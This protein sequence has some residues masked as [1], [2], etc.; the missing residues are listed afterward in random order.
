MGGDPMRRAGVLGMVVAVG[1]GAGHLLSQVFEVAVDAKELSGLEET[2]TAPA[3]LDAAAP[4]APLPVRLV[5]AGGV[6]IPADTA[7][8]GTSYSHATHAFDP[9]FLDAAPWIDPDGAARV[10]AD[11]R[12]YLERMARYGNNAVTVDVFLELILFEAIGDGFAVYGPDDPYR[13]RH[14]AF[15][16]F[17]GGLV[18]DARARGMDVYLKQQTS[19]PEP[20]SARF[21]DL[22]IPEDLELLIIRCMS[23]K[24]AERP[25]SAEELRNA[26]LNCAA[27]GAWTAADADA[28]WDEHGANLR[29]VVNAETNVPGTATIVPQE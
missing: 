4:S 28:W 29:K 26:L 8:W 27:A 14:R 12:A 20:P 1:L 2:A 23:R 9:L 7:A 13:A 25:R 15:R 16:A 18:E 17:F 21:P 19:D 6:G 3:T 24:P 10:R 22:D 11:W 5:D